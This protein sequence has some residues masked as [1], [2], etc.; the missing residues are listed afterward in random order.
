MDQ[1]L[2]GEEVMGDAMVVG[3]ARKKRERIC[4]GEYRKGG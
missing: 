3:F 2:E 4:S 1:E